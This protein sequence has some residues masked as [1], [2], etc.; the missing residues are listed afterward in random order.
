MLK[1]LVIYAS[2]TGNTK[3]IADEIFYALPSDSKEEINVRSWNGRHDA[4]T[5]FVGFWVNRGTC[6]LEVIDLISS[7]HGKNVAFFG[8]CGMGNDPAY[9]KSVEA[10][11]TVWLP[12][13]NRY[14]GSFFCQ[15]SMP[16]FIRDRYEELRGKRGDE[17]ADRM[18]AIFDEGQ[19]HPD[20]QDL[21]RAN[22]FA[23]TA[24]H[25]IPE[26]ENYS[27]LRDIL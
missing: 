6:S 23:D 19:R 20:K 1:Y 10:I 27:H 21:L 22:V 9:Y 3:K 24:V 18:I 17:F 15:G 7:L 4:E 2:E 5:Y 26:Q 16:A 12:A 8:T 14:L 25:R 13:D 11:A